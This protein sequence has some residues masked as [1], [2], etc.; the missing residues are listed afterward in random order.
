[1]ASS[2]LKY[3][4]SSVV[5][6]QVMALTGLL[7]C[8]F[9]LTHLAG[10]CLMYVGPEAFN[11]YAH[12]L[13]TNPAIYLAEAILAAIFLTHIGLAA[14][15]TIE[16]RN[17]RPQKYFVKQNTGRGATFASSTMPYTGLII[18]I[19]LIKHLIDFKFGPLH[20]VTYG[21]VEMRDIYKTVVDYFASPVSVIWYVFCMV[22][23]GIHVSHGFWSAFQSFGFWHPKYTCLLRC[24]SKIF[25]VIVTVGYSA[26]PIYCY[27]QGGN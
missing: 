6:K 1:M 5:K 10:N 14:K 13:I 17:A 2:M 22:A 9:L 19:F 12:A 3:A 18:L 23:L 21:G 20:V 27:L 25:A 16:N 15:L 7:L 26:L 4:T 8:G 24:V 11:R